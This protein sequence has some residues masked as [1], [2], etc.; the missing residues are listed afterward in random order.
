VSKNT[1]INALSKEDLVAK[2]V[3][4]EH[5]IALLQKMV[6]GPRSERFKVAA[7]V[8][9][10]Q[11]SLGVSTDPIAQVEVKKSAVKEHDRSKV[12]LQAKKHPGRTPLPSTLRRE[13]IIIEPNEDVSGCTRLEDEVT[14]SFRLVPSRKVFQELPCWRCLS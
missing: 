10:N 9:V 12:K 7:E 3:N 14:A 5:Q 4:L 6:F 8:P 2:V 13:E 1:D 11:L